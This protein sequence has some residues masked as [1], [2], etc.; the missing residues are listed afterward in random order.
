[1]ITFHH[2]ENENYKSPST[3]RHSPFAIRRHSVFILQ[4]PFGAKIDFTAI[5]ILALPRELILDR[6]KH[7]YKLW[8]NGKTYHKVTV[9][10]QK[11]RIAKLNFDPDNPSYPVVILVFLIS[12][13]HG[14]YMITFHHN[15]WTLLFIDHYWP[16]ASFDLRSV[17]L[18]KSWTQDFF[19]LLGFVDDQG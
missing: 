6:S 7:T 5:A 17:S 10:W 18:R 13:T 15:E 2:N 16:F 8:Y 12:F 4:T 9:N 1:M 11:N 3:V 14:T 19:P